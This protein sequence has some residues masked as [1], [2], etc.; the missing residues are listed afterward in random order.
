MSRPT[1]R[2][3]LVN[4]RRA[5]L[6]LRAAGSVLPQ[7][8]AG[9]QLIV[10][11]NASGD[12]SAE[13]L[14]E[15]GLEVVETSENLGF[16]A[17]VNAGA[18]GMSEDV[19][20]LLNNDAVA[21]EGF[22]D[23]LTSPL[24]GSRPDLG[25]TTA[26][27]LL[28]GRWRPASAQEEA[29]TRADGTR[30]ARVEQAAAAA[31]EGVLLVNSTGNVVDAS[32]NGQDRDWLVPLDE[33]DSPEEVFG[34]C[35]GACAVRA[36]LWRRLGGL[37]ED[38]FMYYEDTDLSWRLHEAGYRVAFVR[39]AVVH[40]EHAAS[41]G[42]GSEM[43]VRVNARNRVLVAVEHAPARVAVAALVRTGARALRSG[44]RGPGASG[45]GQALRALPSALARR[46][47]R[48]RAG[49]RRWPSSVRAR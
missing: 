9:D 22:L 4:W 38:L 45:A 1:A 49:G 24:D 35:G 5:D 14:R 34:V 30:W 23:A 17:G 29:L 6:T 31:G 41:S 18:A 28:A 10:V 42:T 8:G 20:V 25:A 46:A 15:A 11:D 2:V 37:R 44:L 32:G 40:H 3:V 16:G 19:L 33:L 43:F 21:E 7:L 27:M 47:R 13:V 26:L 48:H 36:D 12:G 39:D